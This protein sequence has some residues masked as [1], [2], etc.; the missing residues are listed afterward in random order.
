[1]SLDAKDAS[2]EIV[3]WIRELYGPPEQATLGGILG[4]AIFKAVL[5][6][7][8]Y[9][10]V[11]LEPS[12]RMEAAYRRGWFRS[13]FARATRLLLKQRCLKLLRYLHPAIRGLWRTFMHWLR[14]DPQ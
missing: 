13:F 1:M 6:S 9:A 10:I 8:G 12:V 7:A 3:G 2:V 4:G 11:P 5:R 14:K